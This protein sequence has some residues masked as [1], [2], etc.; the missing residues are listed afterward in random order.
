MAFSI[1][2]QAKLE[3]TQWNSWLNYYYTRIPKSKKETLLS[4]VGIEF[5]LFLCLQLIE[6]SE[7]LKINEQRK[8]NDKLKK[9]E[10][11]K[12]Q[13]NQMTTKFLS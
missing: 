11:R 9:I 2:Y 1:E 3:K 13:M 12:K 6:T 10:N 5:L 4:M 8:T 7:I